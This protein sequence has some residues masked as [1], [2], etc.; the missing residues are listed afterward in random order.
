MVL[1]LLVVA[2]IVLSI[3][4]QRKAP[5]EDS[6]L[7]VQ[8]QRQVL[9]DTWHTLTPEEAITPDDTLRAYPLGSV[10]RAARLDDTWGSVTVTFEDDSSTTLHRD[11]TPQLWL[12]R[13]GEYGKHGVY[14][15]PGQAH[16]LRVR[17]ID[18]TPQPA[19]PAPSE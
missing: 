3:Y 12:H 10:L 2:M 19:R 9:F 17:R 5:P 14:L 18:V 15:V 4:W 16:Q 13:G 11:T 7:L 1:G 8:G 6:I